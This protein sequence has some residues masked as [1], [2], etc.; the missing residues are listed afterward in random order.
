MTLDEFNTIKELHSELQKVN[1]ILKALK[2]PEKRVEVY[3]KISMG[4]VVTPETFYLS[5]MEDVTEA[6]L[7]LRK[8]F[9]ETQLLEL[10][11]EV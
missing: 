1:E 8:E 3:A 7:T 5:D 2:N 4:S 9:L 11:L 6:V 10:G